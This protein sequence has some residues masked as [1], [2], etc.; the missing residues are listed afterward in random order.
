MS[1]YLFGICSATLVHCTVISISSAPYLKYRER[2][3]ENIHEPIRQ[4]TYRRT[5]APKVDSDH[6]AQSRSLIRIFTGYTWI[7]KDA[8]F[9]FH[10]DN[11]D[12]DHTARIRRLI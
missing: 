8:K 3:A 11:E 6:P 7:A 1:W 2:M 10:A 4:K 12:F 9:F 5:K